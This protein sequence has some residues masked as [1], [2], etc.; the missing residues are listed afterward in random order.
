MPDEIDRLMRMYED[1]F[2]EAVPWYGLTV[3]QQTNIEQTIQNA[4]DSGKPIEVKYEKD[5]LY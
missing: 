1:K 4:L 5:A 2:N 3:V